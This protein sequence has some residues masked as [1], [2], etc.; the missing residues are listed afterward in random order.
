MLPLVPLYDSS[1]SSPSLSC[2]QWAVMGYFLRSVIF[3][4]LLFHLDPL[5]N[6]NTHL[7]SP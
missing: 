3:I 7:Q 4:N 5:P 2:D 1:D 6:P